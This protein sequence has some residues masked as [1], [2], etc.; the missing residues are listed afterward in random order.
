MRF[1]YRFSIPKIK[2]KDDISTGFLVS[3]DKVITTVHSIKEYL[4]DNENL[5]EIIFKD[6]NGNKVSR[7]GTPILPIRSEIGVSEIIALKLDET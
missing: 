3:E 5:I 7:I 1:K 4:T 6:K 2:C